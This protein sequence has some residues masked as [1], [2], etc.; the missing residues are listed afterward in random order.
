MRNSI[1]FGNILAVFLILMIPHVNAIEYREVTEIVNHQYQ[2]S[3]QT[4]YSHVSV[5]FMK[6]FID[7][8]IEIVIFIVDSIENILAFLAIIILAGGHRDPD[9]CPMYYFIYLLHVINLFIG[10]SLILILN[11]I[12]SLI[13]DAIKISNNNNSYRNSKSY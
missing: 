2:K 13:D 3:V 6:M 10:Q 11:F 8:L 12:S 9:D 7:R 5:N 4:M 1:L